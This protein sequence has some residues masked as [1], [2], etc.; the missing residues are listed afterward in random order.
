[1]PRK[2]F[3]SADEIENSLKECRSVS[4]AARYLGIDYRTMKRLAE[5]Y[6]LFEK[7]KNQSGEGI[8]KSREGCIDLQEILNGHATIGNK[9]YLKKLLIREK[10]F[11]EKCCRCGYKEKRIIDHS[12]PLILDFIDGNQEN[13]QLYNLRLLCPNCY[14][15]EKVEKKVAR[16][17]KE[18]EKQIQPNVDN[19]VSG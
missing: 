11:E 17:L 14:F 18:Y 19:D 12:V 2:Y 8:R 6:G 9:H 5:I 3:F 16:I 10:V 15:F 13:Q 4:A 1:M 7:Y